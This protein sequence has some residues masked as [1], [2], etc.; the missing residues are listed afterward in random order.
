VENKNV[1]YGDNPWLS[2]NEESNS[3]DTCIILLLCDESIFHKGWEFGYHAHCSLDIAISSH[4]LDDI[5][6]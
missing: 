4:A 5:I 2:S 3:I 6:P 1:I